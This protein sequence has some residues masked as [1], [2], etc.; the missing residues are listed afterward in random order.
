MSKP[1]FTTFPPQSPYIKLL[2]IELNAKKSESN[3]SND[4]KHSRICTIIY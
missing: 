4:Q 1:K 3:L 2:N